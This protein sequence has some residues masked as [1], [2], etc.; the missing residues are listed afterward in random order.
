[1]S[2][3]IEAKTA[4]G[5]AGIA[6]R[7]IKNNKTLGRGFDDCFEMGDGDQVM[8]YIINKARN[9]IKLTLSIKNKDLEDLG[10]GD[11]NKRLRE[12]MKECREEHLKSSLTNENESIFFNTYTI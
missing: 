10:Y 3:A 7:M 1:M 12:A 11:Y 5:R 2:A 9:D 4:K 8:N 6:I